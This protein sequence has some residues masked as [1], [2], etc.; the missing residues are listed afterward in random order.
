MGDFFPRESLNTIG[1]RLLTRYSMVAEMMRLG[2]RLIVVEC[3]GNY[4]FSKSLAIT[5]SPFLIRGVM[6]A[7]FFTLIDLLITSQMM[8]LSKE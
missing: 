8:E 4:S 3:K 1:S 6:Y 5:T 2:L 7:S